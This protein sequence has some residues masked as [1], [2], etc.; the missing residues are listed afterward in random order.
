MKAV[1][2]AVIFLYM[3]GGG[4]LTAAAYLLWDLPG[5]L[6]FAGFAFIAAAQQLRKGMN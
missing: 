5:A 6:I 1:I 4:L 2:A 3:I